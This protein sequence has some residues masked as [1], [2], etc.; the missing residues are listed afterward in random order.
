MKLYVKRHP[1]KTEHF[2]GVFKVRVALY[3]VSG[4]RDVLADIP[5]I[6]FRSALRERP[7]DYKRLENGEELIFDLK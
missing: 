5:W 4:F 1:E 3:T 6:V 7:G 2:M